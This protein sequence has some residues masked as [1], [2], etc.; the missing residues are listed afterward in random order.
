MAHSAAYGQLRSVAYLAGQRAD[1]ATTRTQN[2]LMPFGNAIKMPQEQL[3]RLS[4][5]SPQ[6]VIVGGGGFRR[7]P[8]PVS[9]RL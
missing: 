5:V 7:P 8:N 6:L 1:H 4:A 3:S 9:V 2:L